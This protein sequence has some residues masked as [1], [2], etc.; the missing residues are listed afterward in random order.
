MKFAIEFNHQNALTDV[1][2]QNT[3]N[4]SGDKPTRIN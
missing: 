3:G 4:R 2:A 1:A